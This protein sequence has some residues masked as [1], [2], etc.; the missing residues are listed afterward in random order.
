M[1]PEVIGF[2]LSKAS[3]LENVRNLLKHLDKEGLKSLLDEIAAEI[4][5]F[6]MTG[7]DMIVAFLD[8]LETEVILEY[9]SRASLI[10]SISGTNKR[11]DK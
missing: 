1:A 5:V 9:W 10:G 2:T 8:E 3:D 11:K 7:E 6:T 4:K